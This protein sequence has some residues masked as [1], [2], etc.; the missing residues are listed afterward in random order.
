MIA[1]F[2]SIMKLPKIDATDDEQLPDDFDSDS[3]AHVA[4][5]GSGS[6][7]S[8]ADHSNSIQDNSQLGTKSQDENNQ[9]DIEDTT[10]PPDLEDNL[11][12]MHP[13]TT[14]TADIA[15]TASITTSSDNPTIIASP[16]N[17]DT[18]SE[19]NKDYSTT[20]YERIMYNSL[21]QSNIMEYDMMKFDP[22]SFSGAPLGGWGRATRSRLATLPLRLVVGNDG[23]GGFP[24][25]YGESGGE[26]SDGERRTGASPAKTSDDDIIVPT[27]DNE[28]ENDSNEKRKL[29][30]GTAFSSPSSSFNASIKHDA[31]GGVQRSTGPHFTIHDATGQRYVCRAYAEDELIV[32]SRIDSVFNPAITI[33]DDIA[34]DDVELEMGE[35]SG[36]RA[37]ASVD[38]GQEGTKKPRQNSFH[39]N[40]KGGL[41]GVDDAGNLPETIRTSV[42][43]LLRK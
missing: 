8:M 26:S 22:F 2:L 6:S 12:T 19:S 35:N 28:S 38:N 16:A 41:V 1:L 24:L 3:D 31:T 37:K 32:R 10:I 33:W 5:D 27:P 17:E 39:F 23:S 13:A 20:T 30:D 18:G 4:V 21:F 36:G 11:P 14:S 40:I 9:Q 29:E 42:A 25:L 34:H 43:K 15:T 7:S